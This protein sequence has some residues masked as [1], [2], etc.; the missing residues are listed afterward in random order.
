MKEQVVLNTPLESLPVGKAFL[1]YLVPSILGMLLIAINIVVD[2]VMVGNKLGSVALAGI[3]IAGPVYTLFIAISIWVSIGGA[4]IYSQAMGAKQIT[5]AKQIFSQSITLIVL[6]TLAIGIIAFIFR[7]PLI[8]A[9]GANDE[10]YPYVA[11]YLNIKLLFGFVYTLENTLSV[12][13][14]N[15]GS[16]NRSMAAQITF[17]LSN[18]II[19]YLVLYVFELGVA[20]VAFGTIVS[21]FLGFLVLLPHFFK[22]TGNLKLRKF[23]WNKKT[24]LAT[25]VIGLSSFIAEVGISVFTISHNVILKG[26]GGTT[27]VS[28]FTIVN[29]LHSVVLLAFLGLG[30]A[31]Q[32]LISYYHG[33]KFEERKRQTLKLAVWTAFGLGIFLLIVAQIFTSPIVRIFGNFSNEVTNVAVNGIKIFVFAYVFMGINFIMMTY[34]QSI[35]HIK[36]AIWITTAREIILML[37]FI[38]ILPHYIGINGVWTAVPLAEGIVLITIYAYYKKY[39][40]DQSS[41]LKN[42]INKRR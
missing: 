36:M 17:A 41:I 31:I 15:D 39:I 10:T 30:S 3:G 23:K 19:N 28:A 33:G 32:P 34:F 4:T 25:C 14:R 7:E 2:G 40:V 18:I 26:I 27:S 8:Y 42:S 29:Y 16:P 9:L 13:V 35:T 22:K 38:S 20:A 24:L 5:K 12:F 21:A 11:A 6:I 1:K 37:L